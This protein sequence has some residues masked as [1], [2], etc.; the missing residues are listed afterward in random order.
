M[1]IDRA[2]IAAGPTVQRR[3]VLNAPLPVSDGLTAP[4]IEGQIY[5]RNVVDNGVGGSGFRYAEIYVAVE[6]DTVLTWVRADFGVYYDRYTGEPTDPM[7]FGP[8]TIGTS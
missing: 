5:M 6:I 1:A 3:K 4:T 2:R 8:G 7:T